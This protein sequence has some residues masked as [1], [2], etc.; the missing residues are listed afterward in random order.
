MVPID[1]CAIWGTTSY[2][3][4]WLSIN[5][6]V[7]LASLMAIAGAY[8]LSSFFSGGTRSK[9]KGFIRFE[10]I[11]LIIS[12]AILG[13]ALGLAASA[14]HI[15]TSMSSSLSKS[16]LNPFAYSDLYVAKTFN[17]GL[18]LL[19]N[20]Y[21]TSVE[22]QIQSSV[23]KLI[24][25][26]V[27][28]GVGVGSLLGKG[29]VLAQ[30]FN[31][32][33]VKSELNE[34]GDAYETTGTNWLWSPVGTLIA[35]TCAALSIGCDYESI[36]SL[37][38]TYLYNMFSSIYT[39]VFAPILIVSVGMMFIQFLALP[40]M[41]FTA[42]AIVLPV[43]IA[44]RSIS[45]FSSGLGDAANALIALS[46]VLYIVYPMMV[47]FNSYA[48]SWVFS[49]SNPTYT[50]LNSAFTVNTVSPN[51][52]FQNTG[53][54]TNAI[55]SELGLVK[56]AFSAPGSYNYWFDGLNL[57]GTMRNYTANMAQFFFQAILLFA[58]DMA[59][60]TGLG[61]SI[62]KALRGGLGESGR[63]W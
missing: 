34:A 46:I 60:A 22:Y 11:Q 48:I 33:N 13:M 52:F 40:L 12:I 17:T 54:G 7:I 21:S 23:I 10:L 14:C 18:T 3:N 4:S 27:L 51:S 1:T 36:P 55:S 28:R 44:L 43:A 62:Y 42:F 29:S 19:S 45:F 5:I 31:K 41:Q 20:I 6:L 59:V 9:I 25:A 58:L 16:S 26:G 15:S 61:V 57:V 37:D 50:Y 32:G 38:I 30:W 35:K 2:V 63:F 56:S 47:A 53:P 49:Q 39:D 24:P 8:S